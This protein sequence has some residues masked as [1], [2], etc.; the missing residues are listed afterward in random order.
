MLDVH[1]WN[2]VYCVWIGFDDGSHISHVFN[3]YELVVAHLARLH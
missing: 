1:C 2:D 3:S